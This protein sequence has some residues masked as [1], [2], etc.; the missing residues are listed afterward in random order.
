MAS[1][2]YRTQCAERVARAMVAA[3]V[4]SLDAD[5]KFQKAIKATKVYQEILPLADCPLDAAATLLAF[6]EGIGD[7]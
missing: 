5:K 6:L 7:A 4:K 1:E 2:R 3:A